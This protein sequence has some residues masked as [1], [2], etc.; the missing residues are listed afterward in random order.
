M[1]NNLYERL[2]YEVMYDPDKWGF[3]PGARF[4]TQDVRYMLLL[5]VFAEGTI[6]LHRLRK[7]LYRVRITER[8]HKDTGKTYQKMHE[9]RDIADIS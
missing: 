8:A 9:I 7:K 5:N 2:P 6:L 3:N 1:D 4:N